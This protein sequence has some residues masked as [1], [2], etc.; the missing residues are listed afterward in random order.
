[1][2]ENDLQQLF[3]D[4][5]AGNDAFDA[6]EFTR[7]VNESPA[8]A[9]YLAGLAS[10][11]GDAV[12]PDRERVISGV[13]HAIRARRRAR[14]TR[15]A[16]V[17]ALLLAGA[18]GWWYG[19]NRPSPVDTPVAA[20]AVDSSLARLVLAD[21]EVLSLR[22]L[23]PGTIIRED[24]VEMTREDDGTITYS[25]SDRE[26][27]ETARHTLV[28]PRGNEFRLVLS[29][30]TEVRVN[31]GT[32]IRYPTRFG[33]GTREVSVEGEAFF[34]VAR[35][36]TRAF[37]VTAGEMRVE[38][39]G[40]SFNVN[41]YRD[42]GA[43]LATLVE[44]T[45]RV[46]GG[47]SGE[48]LLSRPGQQASLLENELTVRD[49]DLTETIAWING[50]FLYNDMPLEEICKQ[51]ERWY[52]VHF[53]FRYPSPRAYTFTGVIKRYHSLREILDYIEET[54]SVHFVIDGREVTVYAGKDE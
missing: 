53:Y 32:V 4:F 3:H 13:M 49:V 30:G 21:G 54:T 44:G 42:R 9:R 7:A 26:G 37:V 41:T 14:V 20:I 6:R 45:V 31:S 17:V 15:V 5:L 24:G 52:D 35:D 8:L 23:S 40:T 25:T 43:L 19:S 36:T 46:T 22:D 28:V 12:A 29:D 39:L 18:G 11:S 51:M 47:T 48:C 34:R 50:Q 33:D 1:M 38:A 16:A 2:N 10:L 27:G